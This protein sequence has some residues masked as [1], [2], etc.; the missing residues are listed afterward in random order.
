MAGE[1]GFAMV[2]FV[3][4]PDGATE[5]IVVT[6]ASAPEFGAALRA[7]VETWEFRPAIA[8]G[9]GTA[10]SLR[11]R[12]NLEAVPRGQESAANP[13]QRTLALLRAGK[14]GA[15]TKLDAK[16]TPVY[17]VAPLYPASL[18]VGSRRAGRAEIE[19]TIDREGRCRFPRI[20]SATQPEFGWSAAT[21]VAQWVFQ[22]PM[23]EGK[24]VDVLVKI[25]FEFA[26]K[27]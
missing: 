10:V 17:R 7:A 23:R 21:A 14:I 1:S 20:V 16:L 24:P 8:G 25:P 2:D 11:K 4:R 22:P 26:A 12:A 5:G 13:A 18:P 27:D 19:F 3:V 9:R 6:E 15:A